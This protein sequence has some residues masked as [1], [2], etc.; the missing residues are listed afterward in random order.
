MSDY[1]QLWKP[2]SE[3]SPYQLNKTYGV[4][5]FKTVRSIKSKYQ[6]DINTFFTK[7]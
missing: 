1:I 2:W 3:I 7:I 6:L 4:V 5:K